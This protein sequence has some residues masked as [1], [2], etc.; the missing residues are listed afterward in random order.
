MA[1]RQMKYIVIDG[2]LNDLPIMFPASESHDQMALSLKHLGDVISA[3]F[4]DLLDDGGVSAYGDS[5]SLKIK[6]RPEDTALIN[7]YMGFME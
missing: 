5:H 3:G 6:S 1:A 2:Y 4:V 7:R